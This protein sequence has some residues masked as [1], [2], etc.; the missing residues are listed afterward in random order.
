MTVLCF[1]FQHGHRGFSYRF[2]V[3]LKGEPFGNGKFCDE[4]FEW[5]L[6]G[7]KTQSINATWSE[8]TT[9]S[10]ESSDGNVSDSDNK[11]ID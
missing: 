5:A 7:A 1:P 2:Y 6:E 3:V 11:D 4:T 10:S 9:S 8:E